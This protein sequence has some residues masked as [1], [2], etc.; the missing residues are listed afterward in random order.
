MRR[1]ERRHDGQVSTAL[2][3][4]PTRAVP[5]QADVWLDD[6]GWHKRMFLESRFRWTGE[7]VMSIV[8]RHTGGQLS[9]RT[10]A[11]LELLRRY[12]GQVQAYSDRCRLAM[13]DPLLLARATLGG[14]WGPT[15]RAVGLS[16]V[17]CKATVWL[18]VGEPPEART[19]LNVARALRDLPFVNPLIEAWELKQVWRMYEAAAG[20]VE[21]AICDLVDELVGSRPA[22]VLAVAAGMTV[23][24]MW[25][26][27]AD[28]H[29]ARGW[30]GDPRRI[31]VQVF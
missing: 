13:A 10:V 31:P 17:D 30:P 26:R 12:Q 29:D 25:R 19:N 11:H 5:A 28:A 7:H 18:A 24:G 20:V 4:G 27:I 2:G 16:V 23:G 21:D 1:R 6:L 8:T 22:D 3:H 9:F 15:G 14:G